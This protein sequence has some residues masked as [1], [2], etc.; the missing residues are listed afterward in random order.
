MNGTPDDQGI[1]GSVT[2]EW[3]E[4]YPPGTE[5]AETPEPPGAQAIDPEPRSRT[6]PLASGLFGAALLLVLLGSI[7]PLFRAVFQESLQVV[8]LVG[9]GAW[10][11][12]STSRILVPSH[13]QN[14]RV[15][16]SPFPM[17]YPLVIAGLLVLAAACLV[18]RAGWR[19]SSLRPARL[20]G[21]VGATFLTGLVFALGMFE[22]AWQSVLSA[23]G[24]NVARVGPA[25]GPGQGFWLL[26]VAAMVAIAGAVLT[27]RMRPVEPAQPAD[28]WGEQD[29]EPAADVP[30]G[31]PAEWPVVAVIPADERSHW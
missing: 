25:A 20:V 24:G 31:Q 6:G 21:V 17:G 29:P 10:R 7:L 12:T 15:V 19:P 23:P 26:V 11:F 3:V 14:T 16:P 5:P 4:V 1:A 2:G 22:L 27:F 8:D 18:V 13:P 9:V 28:Q 30:P